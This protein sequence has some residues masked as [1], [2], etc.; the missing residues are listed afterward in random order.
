MIQ[1]SK[2]L[3]KNSYSLEYR[4]ECEVRWL[5]TLPL[6]NRRDYLQL[7]E[8]KRNK[9]AREQLEQGLITLWNNRK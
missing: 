7:V 8:V 3:L 6:Q 5:T 1:E 4:H 9:K 2:L